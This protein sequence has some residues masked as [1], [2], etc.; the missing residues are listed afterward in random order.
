MKASTEAL[1]STEVHVPTL[2]FINLD[3]QFSQLLPKPFLNRP[4]QPVMSWV[5][6]NQDHQI[7]RKSCVPDV[8]VLAEARGLFRPLQHP[9]SRIMEHGVDEGQFSDFDR[10]SGAMAVAFEIGIERVFFE[11]GQFFRFGPEQVHHEHAV[12][13][14]FAP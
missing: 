11:F 9:V 7:V 4:H 12:G 2:L 1:A 6:V 5:G 3:L 14:C 8:G 10:R 13:S